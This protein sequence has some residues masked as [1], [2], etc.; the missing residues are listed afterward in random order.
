MLAG[1]FIRRWSLAGRGDLFGDHESMFGIAT[2]WDV[3]LVVFE[4]LAVR[5]CLAVA[6]RCA[7]VVLGAE[8]L[9]R[10]LIGKPREALIVRA[11]ALL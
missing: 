11:R 6:R 8:T 7:P 5:Y 3:F 2:G 1:T 4:R 9:G 10:C